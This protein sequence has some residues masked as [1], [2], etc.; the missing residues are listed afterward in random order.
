MKSLGVFPDVSEAQR[1]LRAA[2]ANAQIHIEEVAT[3]IFVANGCG[4]QQAV[5]DMALA[6]KH[7]ANGA[8]DD[9]PNWPSKEEGDW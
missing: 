8:F 7:Q 9:E 6:L 1:L 2:I 3:Q 4:D 5:R